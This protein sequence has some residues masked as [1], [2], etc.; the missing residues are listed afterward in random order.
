MK[1]LAG[2]AWR[3]RRGLL[4]SVALATTALLA[5][6]ILLLA[7]A[8]SERRG[9]ELPPLPWD[10]IVVPKATEVF[11]LRQAMFEGVAPEDVLP[12]GLLPSLEVVGGVTHAASL[13]VVAYVGGF[14]LAGADRAWLERPASA[15]PPR[16]IAGRWF[17]EA[18]AEAV[19]GVAAAEALGLG[20]G[21]VLLARASPSE[22]F[23]E[24]A[25]ERHGQALPLSWVPATSPMGPDT[26]HAMWA[27]PLEVVGIID[28]GASPFDRLILTSRVHTARYF[29]Q[30]QLAGIARDVSAEGVTTFLY[31]NAGN[32]SDRSR[33]LDLLERNSVA[34]A[35]SVDAEADAI[36][37]WRADRVRWLTWVPFVLLLGTLALV[38]F[39]HQA[40]TEPFRGRAALLQALGYSPWQVSGAWTGVIGLALAVAWALALPLAS[41]VAA[42][43]ALTDRAGLLSHWVTLGGILALALVASFVLGGWVRHRRW[44]VAR[45]LRT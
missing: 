44:S 3:H 11:P 26:P 24:Q 30:Q 13:H 6:V 7:S 33:L 39:T 43:A 29:L 34:Q 4:L 37:A 16:M 1:A 17:N 23:V 45:E 22:T 18:G 8:E 12:W 20:L 40:L 35:L 5:L 25:W 9:A 15:R 42:S 21:D 19:V 14:P 28:H 32:A 41:W 38:L 2:V 31:L 27:Q 10:I 36:R